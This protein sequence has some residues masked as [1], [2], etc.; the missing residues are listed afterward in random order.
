M[1]GHSFWDPHPH[2]PSPPTALPGSALTAALRLRIRTLKIRAMGPSDVGGGHRPPYLGL[3]RG[4]SPHPS[5]PNLVTTSWEK[6]LASPT[7][8]QPGWPA[9][10]GPHPHR[11]GPPPPAATLPLLVKYS[12]FAL[13]PVPVLPDLVPL[14]PS[15]PASSSCLTGPQGLGPVGPQLPGA[16]NTS[17][18][19]GPSATC[20]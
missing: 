9:Q 5:S 17:P 19:P 7:G 6:A 11:R 2:S 16:S 3:M 10:P 4:D 12:P 1:T 8:K 18:P 13:L 20:F 15:T 14:R